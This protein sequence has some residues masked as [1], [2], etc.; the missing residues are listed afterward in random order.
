MNLPLMAAGL[1]QDNRLIDLAKGSSRD[2][3]LDVGR[4]VIA[5]P[6]LPVAWR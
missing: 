5:V 3:T 2:C 1:R 4:N 6:G